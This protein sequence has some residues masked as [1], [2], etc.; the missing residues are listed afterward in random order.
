MTSSKAQAGTYQHA[1]TY[2]QRGE[3][4]LNTVWTVGHSTRT[5]EE[6]V[7]ALVANDIELVVDVRRFPASRRLPHFNTAE[8]EEGLTGAGID[9]KWMPSLGGRRQ[10]RPDSPNGGWTHPAFRGDADHTATEEFAEGLTDLLI[11][12][13][14]VRTAVMCAELLWWRCH[15]RIIGDVL[16]SLEYE[17][18]HIR[19]A[20]F[21]EK[22]KLAPPGRVID[23]ELSYAPESQQTFR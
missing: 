15:R 22:H 18:I 13:G 1:V 21:S 11:L 7:A 17:V 2:S 19:D 6:F 8:L 10:P 20:G 3:N 16:V 23:G 14:G 9:Y 4:I 5:L 12:S